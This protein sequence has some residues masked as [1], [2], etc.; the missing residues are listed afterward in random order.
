MVRRSLFEQVGGF[1]EQFL[2]AQDTLFCLHVSL[3]SQ[4]DRLAKPLTFRRVREGSLGSGYEEKRRYL[5]RVV[6]DFI[7]VEPQFQDV[8]S[9]ALYSIDMHFMR[10]ATGNCSVYSRLSILRTILRHL[11]RR[12]MYPLLFEIMSGRVK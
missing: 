4:M 3:H 7:A 6:S 1:D 8:R 9:D 10:R 2:K 11:H 5:Y 12:S